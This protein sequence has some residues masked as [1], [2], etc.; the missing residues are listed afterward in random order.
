MFGTS[1]TDTFGTEVAGSLRIFRR[2]GIGT[3]AHGADFINPAHQLTEVAGVG[4]SLNRRNF[5]F[6]NLAFGTV[7]RNPVTFFDNNA[8]LGSHGLLGIINGNIR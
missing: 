7:Q 8:G 1:Q 6:D 4:I 3:N 2:F 5:A